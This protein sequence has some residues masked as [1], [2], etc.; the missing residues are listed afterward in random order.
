MRWRTGVGL[1]NLLDTKVRSH[2]SC[3]AIAAPA[4]GRH[5]EQRHLK[6]R[7]M[8]GCLL[9]LGDR[10]CPCPGRWAAASATASTTLA[11]FAAINN[12]RIDSNP[13]AF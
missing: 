2:G 9:P 7:S 6:R 3:I 10:L 1:S 11:T 13:R 8:E 5:Q 4:E 12:T